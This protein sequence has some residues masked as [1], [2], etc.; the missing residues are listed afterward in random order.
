M[1]KC[2]KQNANILLQEDI[3]S[4]LLYKTVWKA[5]ILNKNHS[6]VTVFIVGFCKALG[7]EHRML[8]TGYLFWGLNEN[9]FLLLASES[10]D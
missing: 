3:Y 9:F 1:K 4:V 8:A 7:F 10:C 2:S 6:A 5:D